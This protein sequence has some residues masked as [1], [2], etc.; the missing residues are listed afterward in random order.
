MSAP[1][2]LVGYCSELTTQPG[3]KLSFMVSAPRP[4]EADLVRLGGVD[5]REGGT[6]LSSKEPVPSDFHGTYPSV[7]Q[8]TIIGS[9]GIA[10]LDA[11]SD[12][13]ALTCE[14]W[15]LPTRPLAGRQVL[16]HVTG[17]GGHELT[18]VIDSGVLTL[19][20]DTPAGRVVVHADGRLDHPR[21]V[22]LVATYDPDA[23]QATL[24][25]WTVGRWPR[26]RT[27]S[28]T[29]SD[30]RPARAWRIQGVTLAARDGVSGA[31]TDFFDGRLESPRVWS[32]AVSSDALDALGADQPLSAYLPAEAVIAAWDLSQALDGDT[33][34]DTSGQ[35]HHGCLRNGPAR[36]VIGHGW[37]GAS[38]RH[39][40]VPSEW[41]AA[42]FHGDDLRDA[43]WTPTFTYDV[44]ADLASGIYA[45]RLRSGEDEYFIPFFVLPGARKARVAFLAPTNTYLAYAN[46]HLALGLRKDAHAKMMGGDIQLTPSD[47]LLA[48][49]PEFGLSIYDT[50]RDGSGVMYT[51]WRRPLVNFQPDYETWSVRGRRELAADL[52]IVGWLESLGVAFDV[53][54]DH[55][56]DEVG[57]ALLDGYDVVITGSHPEYVTEQEL[58]ALE[59]FVASSGR[60]M[61]LGGDGFW[62]VSSYARE[63][64]HVLECR[65]GYAAQRNWT[66]HP[67]EV[68]HSTTG[69]LG[70]AW[71]HRGRAPQVLVGVGLGA[72]GWDQGS[73]FVR[74]EAS[75][76]DD[77][78]HLFE[79]LD[80][81][82]IGDFG[83]VLGGA[84][85]DELDVADARLGTPA[86]AVRLMSSQHGSKYQPTIDTQ[87]SIEPDMGGDV[88]PDV[89]GDVVL[90]DTGNGGRVFS[91]GSM[92]WA[93][94]LGFNNYDNSVATLTTNVLRDF[95]ARS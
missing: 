21:W 27:A 8:R 71:S 61:Y 83:L 45:A 23:G 69:E 49:H 86:Y 22:R 57:A 19:E 64:R 41:G 59:A 76:R 77:L 18:L 44:P 5:T 82:V 81:E 12:S 40:D 74:S 72:V 93:G 66:S 34:V 11:C 50:H 95:L 1:F 20:V 15:A 55:A 10:A 25:T 75:R 89:R 51:S 68:Y 46:E 90:I 33:M 24:A 43:E 94:S 92:C 52:M 26:D 70:A 87:M 62:W 35:Q 4:F 56:L 42:H 88:N 30:A 31:P 17:D 54:T 79:G 2:D 80:G 38:I 39:H 16:F 32:A 37:S 67:A 13:G 60:L 63:D 58:D 78:K 3:G 65:R 91:A 6:G 47:E 84:A 29:T 28:R 9:Y 36:A 7:E 48:R 85:G 73:G 53:I 14:V